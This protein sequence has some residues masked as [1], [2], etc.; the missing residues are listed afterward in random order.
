M[1][2]RNSKV[3]NKNLSTLLNEKNIQWPQ[4]KA[5]IS[6]NSTTLES[7][8]RQA[9]KRAMLD[10]NICKSTLQ[11]LLRR[12]DVDLDQRVRYT[13]AAVR[14]G[15]MT[16]VQTLIYDDIDVLYWRD[17]SNKTLLHFICEKHGWNKEVAFILKETLENRD[18]D[19]HRHE[20]LFEKNE[21][22]EMPLHLAL[23][24]GCD[25]DEVISH[26]K[27]EYPVYLEDHV[28][29]I[30]EVIAEYCDDMIVLQDL[31]LH[32][33]KLLEI[34]LNGSSPLHFACLY[35]N[36]H[37]IR[38]LLEEYKRREGRKLLFQN[39]LLAL[40]NESMS[41]LAYLVLSVGDRDNGNAWRCIDLCIDFF[42]TQIPLLHLLFD[43]MLEQA[44]ERN[45]CI[46]LVREIVAH[47]DL[48]TFVLDE[49]GRSLLSILIPQMVMLPLKD[50]KRQ[51]V[52][53][54]IL[55]YLLENT[56][57]GIN[58]AK[59]RDGQKRLPL[60]V[61][62]EEAL[63]WNSGLDCIVTANVDALDED[64]PVT[65]LAPFALSAINTSCDLNATYLLL[66]TN[67]NVI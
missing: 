4:I 60:H 40:N 57:D 14:C 8:R 10:K 65:K 37:M 25:L 62:C 31:I 17:I 67:P 64:D 51:A 6:K 15:N 13:I 53:K 11:L 41:P 1:K 55:S 33:P 63:P 42:E 22:M 21:D 66:R 3:W 29:L 23:Q 39:R 26:I 49:S 46:R 52:M 9:L 43:G 45:N 30:M 58:L 56:I 20:G 2:G 19:N 7:L 50:K 27:D 38:V 35:Q 48:S 5:I 34:T 36:Q 24:A 47:L 18:F 44:F 16:A 12:T 61:S 32:L 59:I 28:G 54:D